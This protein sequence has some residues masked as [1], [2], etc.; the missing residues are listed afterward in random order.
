MAT[1]ESTLVSGTMGKK[2]R[3]VLRRSAF[4]AVGRMAGGEN[5]IGR[6]GAHAPGLALENSPCQLACCQSRVLSARS[7][8]FTYNDGASASNGG[9]Q[10]NEAI[11]E[12]CAAQQSE[13]CN[14]DVM[15]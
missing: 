12:H 4:S 10:L 14:P 9:T 15:L 2:H 8:G 3:G 11:S 1:L 6:D 7:N 13:R 5:R